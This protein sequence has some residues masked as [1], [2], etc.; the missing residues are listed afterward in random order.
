M[1]WLIGA[2]RMA[3]E[4]SKVLSAQNIKY[5]VIGRSKNH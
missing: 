3:L 1:L 2:G 5:I 4:Y